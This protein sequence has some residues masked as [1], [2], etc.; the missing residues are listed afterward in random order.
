MSVLQALLTDKIPGFD[1]PRIVPWTAALASD[2]SHFAA[3]RPGFT[4]PAKP[5]KWTPS[6]RCGTSEKSRDRGT[7]GLRD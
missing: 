4:L 2:R 7:K 6:K 5:R 3:S 1:P